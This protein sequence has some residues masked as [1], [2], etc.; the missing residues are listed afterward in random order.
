MK[1]DINLKYLLILAVLCFVYLF[2][3]HGI[4]IKIFLILILIPIFLLLNHFNE[5]KIVHFFLGLLSFFLLFNFSYNHYL[6][7]EEILSNI[8][9]RD[10][11][12][13]KMIQFLNKKNYKNT[14]LS[15]DF[16]ILKNVSIHT[17]KNVYFI[18]ITNTNLTE[19]NLTNRF[20]DIIYLYGFNVSDL[21][22][23]FED[24]DLEYQEKIKKIALTN[25]YHMQIHHKEKIIK[26]LLDGY[27]NYLSSN[28][29]KAIKYFDK[30]I[31]NFDNLNYVKNNSFIFEVIKSKQ[32]YEYSNYKIYNCKFDNK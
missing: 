29:Y 23:Y 17:D 4:N 18:N 5:K 32:I 7:N 21:Q 13:K 11:S 28:K 22:A 20:Y 6:K 2:T 15:L 3:Q 19:K 27:K 25:L 12:Q 9:Q 1:K 30:C 8:S 26:K 16:G 14:Y 10:L 24:I 31:I